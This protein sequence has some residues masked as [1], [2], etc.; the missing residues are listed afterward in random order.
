MAE[1][2]FRHIEKLQGPHRWGRFLDAGTGWGSFDWALGLETEA[3]IAVTGSETRREKMWSDF[4]HRLSPA[5]AIV[6]G[7]WVDPQFL[8]QQ[9]FDTVLVDYL[10]G[11][12]DRF[13]PYFQTR[14]FERLRPH[15]GG[16][17]FVV[18]LEPYGETQDHE[19]GIWVNR[20]AALR[21]ATLLLAGDRPHREYPRW[22]VAEQLEKC[23]YRVLAQESFPIL[24]SERFIKAELDVCRANL[25]HLPKTLRSAID[26]YEKQL[27]DQL[28]QRVSQGPLKWGADYVIM[29]ETDER[30]S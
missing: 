9:I 19:D 28:L 13:A 25:N 12:L 30:H 11:S 7:N 3:L 27:R 16:R 23:G 20:L 22:W 14:L 24:Y 15:V 2:L 17:V 18:G 21:D 1:S 5:Q 4:G 10:L 6:C 8:A 29:A 26:S